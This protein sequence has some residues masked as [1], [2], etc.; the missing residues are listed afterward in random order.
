M[1]DLQ[2]R[3]GA[4]GFAAEGD[5]TGIYGAATHRAVRTFQ[6]ARG[7]RLDGICGEQTWAAIVEAGYQ[8][9][10]RRLY[11]RK[12]MM[13]GDDIATLQR[14][15]GSLGFDAGKVDGIFGPDTADALADFQRNAG[16]TADEI[17]GAEELTVLERLGARTAG[18]ASLG[19][20]AELREVAALHH[21]PRSLAGLRIVIGERGGLDGLAN[22]LG[23]MLRRRGADSVV[24]HHPNG[25]DLAQQAN[26]ANAALFVELASLGTMAGCRC[27]YYRGYS[28][29]SPAGQALAECLAATVPG[30]LG[31]AAL[32]TTGMA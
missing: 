4:L 9:G 32:G 7:L 1:A 24:L 30:A 8:L 17:F 14:R 13:R 22:A 21:P 15:L 6:E 2:R 16:L 29:S 10:D 18:P 31:V 19:L 11:Q 3:L 5:S 27:V 25:S 20:V 23:R 26:A 28:T 12:P